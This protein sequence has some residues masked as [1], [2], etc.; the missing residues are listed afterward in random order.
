MAS[1]NINRVAINTVIQYVQLILNVVIGLFSVRLILN[2]LGASDY[3]I[4]DL[5]AGVV[6][7]LMFISTSLSQTSMRYLSV[8]LGKHDDNNTSKV[9]STCL[10]LHVYIALI[11]SLLLIACSL[12]D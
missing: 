6:G 8:S 3:G 1:N 11:L 5:I 7:L 2:A 12:F 9:F 10:W 4:Y